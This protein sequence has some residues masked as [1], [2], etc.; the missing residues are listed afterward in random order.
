MAEKSGTVETHGH[1]RRER[2]LHR[3]DHAGRVVVITAEQGAGKTDLMSQ[4]LSQ[5]RTPAFAWV[6][7]D[8]GASVPRAFWLRLL[9]ALSAARP[10][11]FAPLANDYMSGRVPSEEAPALLLSASMRDPL[12]VTLVIDDLHF[13]PDELQDQLVSLL[14]RSP[15]LRLLAASRSRTRF[16]TPVTAAGLAVTTLHAE[17]LAFTRHEI[18]SAATT[19]PYRL[20]EPEI[21]ALRRTTRG[22][23][24][25]VRLALSVM[26]NLSRSGARRPGSDEVARGVEAMLAGFAPEFRTPQD[27]EL[28]LTASL[29]PEIDAAL[30]EQLGGAST[31]SELER[32][33]ALELGRLTLQH[34]R[35]VFRLHTLVAGALR[36]RA[37]SELP[38]ERV[39]E[40]RHLAFTHLYEHADPIDMLEL[41]VDGNMDRAIFPHFVRN[42][43]EI[44][45]KRSRELISVA[46]SIS[47]ER[48]AREG[49]IPIMIAVALSEHSL[50]PTPRMRDLLEVG[51]PALEHRATEASGAAGLLLLL[52]RFAGLRVSRAYEAAAD[53][54]EQFLRQGELASPSW[55]SGMNAAR[56]QIIVTELLAARIP[57]VLALAEGLADDTHPGRQAHMHSVLAFAYARIGDLRAARRE[58]GA[59]DPSQA[60]W[61]EST[62]SIGWHLAS[63]LR[64]S[65]LGHHDQ[66]FEALSAVAPRMD[67][68]ELW[69]AIVWTRGKARL[70][71][72]Q[73]ALGYQELESALA[74]RERLPLSAGWTEELQTLRGEFL[75]A[76]GDLVG[77]RAALAHGGD[78]ASSRLARARL[79]ILAS[80]P[81]EALV[82][83]DA[84]DAG[85]RRADPDHAAAQQ[86]EARDSET[87]ASAPF[88]AQVAQSQLLRAAIY[89][90]Q[91]NTE[92]ATSLATGALLTLDRLDN[93]L[94]LLW[95]PAAELALIRSLVPADVWRMP[96][97]SPFVGD[98]VVLEQLSKREA[99]VLLEL[100]RGGSIDDIAGD[101]H[102]SSNTIKTQ[103]RSIYKK[104]KVSSRTEALARARQMGLV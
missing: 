1:V 85:A 97:G 16:E 35:P 72:D 26:A 12:P 34:G 80:Q 104:L 103:T 63:A 4:W 38:S 42:Y 56:L 55:R 17:E 19:L 91:G 11:A 94:P 37:L 39:A 67:D 78:G 51:M 87:P 53:A 32:F 23:P 50:V 24:L 36:P 66:A 46:E 33:D 69:P 59:V 88:P 99:L 82:H 73:A 60:G 15:N 10:E 13:A 8:A 20:S 61:R 70:V 64:A 93:R 84:F 43:S 86:A 2:L 77:A 28:A 25:A 81:T 3:L 100:A 83:L 74:A 98:D 68:S 90:R 58:L 29:V 76:T 45:L 5:Q 57:R 75:L 6:G 47:P 31:W 14:R 21:S 71:A 102:V 44:S 79:A 9:Q 89:A 30:A 18:A 92:C 52:A 95:I 22:H 40:V 27:R 7:L 101:L 62:H 49:T 96:P 41:L 65:S 48:Q 54:G